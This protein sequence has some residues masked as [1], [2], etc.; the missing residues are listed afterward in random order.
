MSEAEVS[1][2]AG[3]C[4]RLY[5]AWQSH[6][7]ILELRSRRERSLTSELLRLERLE[8]HRDLQLLRAGATNRRG[9]VASRGRKL[10]AAERGLERVRSDLAKVGSWEPDEE[11]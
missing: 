9:Y 7:R 3:N 6:L 4:P 8:A 2:L 10:A 5:R 1:W 11:S